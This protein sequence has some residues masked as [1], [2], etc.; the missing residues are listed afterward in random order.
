MI[1]LASASNDQRVTYRWDDTFDRY[2]LDDT[3]PE[4]LRSK[5]LSCLKE[6]ITH[7]LHLADPEATLDFVDFVRNEVVALPSPFVLGG[8]TYYRAL[9]L[10]SLGRDEEALAEYVALYEGDPESPWHIL[11]GLHLETN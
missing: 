2:E 6:F 10:E 3:S 5:Y 8:L 11:A 7:C 4:A 9:A 1:I